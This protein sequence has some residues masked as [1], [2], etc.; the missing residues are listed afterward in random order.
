MFHTKYMYM[1]VEAHA[2][3]EVIISSVKIIGKI[4]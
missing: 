1:Y 3:D 4:N 2:K